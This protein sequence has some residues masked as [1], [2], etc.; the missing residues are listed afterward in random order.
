MKNSILHIALLCVLFT[1]CNVTKYVPEDELV[2][3][4]TEVELV[5][6]DEVRNAK[7][8]ERQLSY[9]TKPVATNPFQVW[10]Y[11]LFGPKKEEEKGLKKFFRN[12]L[13]APPNL[14]DLQEVERSAARMKARM[15]DIGFFGSKVKWD[16]I[17]DGQTVMAKYF[18]EGNGQY[19]ISVV[20]FPPD[21]S[22][23]RSI[24]NDYQNISYLESGKYYTK[25]D[26]DAERA[27]VASLLNN[28]G[29]PDFDKNFIYYFVDTTQMDSLTA[30]VYQRVE[31]PLAS[32]KHKRYLIG[33][34]TLHTTYVLGESTD[35]SA[36]DSIVINDDLSEV[37]RYRILKPRTLERMVLQEYGDVFDQADQTATINHF[38]SLGIFKY[39]NMRYRRDTTGPV[40]LMHRD[41]YMTPGPSQTFSADAE[42]NNRVGGFLGTAGS[43]TYSHN[44][45]FN[46]GDRFD[47]RLGAG[48]E[49][50]SGD[51]T[52]F[53]NTQDLD[54][55]VALSVPQLWV[56]FR[57]SKNVNFH[58]PRT[59]LSLANN[60][61]RRTN[62]YTLN[63]TKF[64]FGYTLR[65]DE[66]KTWRIFPI[67]LNRVDQLSITDDFAAQLAETPRLETS[68]ADQFIAG[69]EAVFI[70]NE[71]FGRSGNTRFFVRNELELA[72]NLPSFLGQTPSDAPDGAPEEIL[73]LPYAQYARLNIDF[74]EYIKLAGADNLLVLRVSPGVGYAY[75]NSEFLPYI[76][77]FFVG[78]ANSLR[79]FRLRTVGPGSFVNDVPATETNQLVF[80]DQ[81][82][83]IKLELNAE[84]RFPLV[85]MLKGALF[86]DAGNVWT[87]REDE[88]PEGQFEFQD[89]L[90]ELAIGAGF[91]L[92]IDAEFLVI[93]LD[94]ASPVRRVV[95]GEGFQ[96]TLWQGANIRENLV[97]NIAIGYPF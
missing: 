32:I 70:Y 27:R 85:A 43:V 1:A 28:R 25:A 84:Y 53:I 75:G 71:P 54:F 30:D 48:V 10:W 91:G 40:N 7:K 52:S 18:V 4:G 49:T 33:N 77:Q 45:L 14:L 65:P 24:I 68:F 31:P 94:F 42:V 6:A 92:R 57:K 35:S 64:S 72:G 47:A 36:M 87:L 39:V 63:T 60:F 34:T 73:G 19:K 69:G 2:Y 37:R 79:A 90:N 81:T 17:T 83:D 66:L 23:L 21:T 55:S 11:N 58:V 9:V 50:Q 82:G 12:L 89:A 56:P 59:V 22:N 80:L 76:K 26:L 78:G 96:W 5:N 88:R 41:I 44:N 20:D 8:L 46:G 29:Y 95:P 61:Q 38:L 67:T 93:R 97:T 86:V 16:T 13:G 62:F 3:T 15:R 51:T 74:R